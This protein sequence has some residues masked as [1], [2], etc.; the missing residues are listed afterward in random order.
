MAIKLSGSLSRKLPIQGIPYSSENFSAGLEIEINSAETGE[1]QARLAGLYD[2]LSQA[3][4]AQIT[5]AGAHPIPQPTPAKQ[6]INGNG[7]THATANTAPV[8]QT[9]GNGNRVGNYNGNNRVGAANG[10]GRSIYATQA[11]QRAIFAISKSMNLDLPALLA[12]YNCADVSQLPIRDAS[13][14]IDSLKAR[15]NGAH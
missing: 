14:L 7:K 8:A 11:Q 2:C 6:T 4:D 15:Q 13:T 10:N 12:D 1:V 3:I 5:A 9:N